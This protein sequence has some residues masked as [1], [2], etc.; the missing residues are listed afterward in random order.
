VILYE[1]TRST[2]SGGSQGTPLA[3]RVL[4][5]VGSQSGDSFEPGRLLLLEYGPLPQIIVC[6]RWNI[7][8]GFEE[9]RLPR[10]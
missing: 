9:L 10:L 8:I 7:E 3:T 5:G 2:I 4:L 1:G 6:L